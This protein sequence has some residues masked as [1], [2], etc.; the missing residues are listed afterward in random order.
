MP[1][2]YMDRRVPHLRGVLYLQHVNRPLHATLFLLETENNSY[3]NLRSRG[4]LKP[5]FCEF[6]IFFHTKTEDSLAETASF[7]ICLAE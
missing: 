5:E 2:D 1:R 6:D 7:L 3:C 4:I